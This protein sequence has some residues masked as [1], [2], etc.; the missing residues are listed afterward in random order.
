MC[1]KEEDHGV[2]CGIYVALCVTGGMVS[3]NIGSE[4]RKRYKHDCSFNKS[5]EKK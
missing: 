4:K 1:D 3:T 5:V 2:C